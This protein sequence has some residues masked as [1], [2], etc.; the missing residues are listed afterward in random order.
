MTISCQECPFGSL[1]VVW[2]WL[3]GMWVVFVLFPGSVTMWEEVIIFVE[4]VDFC[5]MVDDGGEFCLP[6]PFMF[7]FWLMSKHVVDNICLLSRCLSFPLVDCIESI[8]IAGCWIGC[9]W[10]FLSKFP[11]WK[12]VL[13][14]EVKWNLVGP[15]WPIVVLPESVGILILALVKNSSYAICF[16]VGEYWD[17]ELF[18]LSIADVELEWVLNVSLLKI[19]LNYRLWMNEHDLI[20]FVL[21]IGFII[22]ELHGND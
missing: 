2:F 13:F 22:K 9:R 1:T 5:C 11:H 14:V 7:L 16:F 6:L 19:C 4:I 21:L 18:Y 17:V 3:V 8:S 15:M 10:W 20:G 12:I